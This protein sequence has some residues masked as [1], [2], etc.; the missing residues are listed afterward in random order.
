MIYLERF[1]F[2]EVNF[3]LCRVLKVFITSNA[4]N[5]IDF[6]GIQFHIMVVKILRLILYFEEVDRKIDE[7]K[8]PS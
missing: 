2:A 1:K 3:D 8:G 6:R 5:T 7:R 4:K